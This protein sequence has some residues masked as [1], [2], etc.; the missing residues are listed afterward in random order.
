[1][2]SS[3]S[4]ANAKREIYM[5]DI[6]CKSQDSYHQFVL[7]SLPIGVAIL[8]MP[9]YIINLTNAEFARMVG[10]ASPACLAQGKSLEEALP[11]QWVDL[12]MPLVDEALDTDDRIMVCKV[13][14]AVIDSETDDYWFVSCQ[15]IPNCNSS[16]KHALIFSQD[17]SEES[18][19]LKRL[20][21]LN[22]LGSSLSRGYSLYEFLDDG[23]KRFASVISADYC[24]AF[25]LDQDGSRLLRVAESKPLDWAPVEIH[26]D[27]ACEWQWDAR[28][29]GPTYVCPPDACNVEARVLASIGAYG[30]LHIPVTVMGSL[31]GFIAAIF[32]KTGY[33]PPQED[34]EFAQL[35]AERCALAITT[36]K[37]MVEY[38]RLL[39]A[40]QALHRASTEKA[41]QMEALLESLECGVLIYDRNG[42]V[43]LSNHASEEIADLGK[44]GSKRRD[45]MAFN[46]PLEYLDGKIVPVEERPYDKLMREGSLVDEDYIIHRADGSTRVVSFS[47]GVI[48]D[49]G[50]MVSSA[51]LILRDITKLHEM[52][53]TRQEMVRLISHDLRSPLTLILAR[54]QM[55]ERL[56]DKPDAVRK[57]A[58]AIIT[59][60]KLMDVMISDLTDSF[61]LQS[62]EIRLRKQAL[63]VE[64]LISDCM[65]HWIGV[66]DLLRLRLDIEPDLPPVYGDSVRLE[67]IL[68]NL[69]TNAFKYSPKDSEVVIRVVL[70]Q[71]EEE[72]VISVI[73][74]G[75][76]VSK[77]ELPNIFERCYRD[78][79]AQN[80]TE[81]LGL[82]LYISKKLVE[83][84]GGRIW[85]RSVVGNGSTFSF[86]IPI[87]R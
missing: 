41:A 67:R 74:Q 27:S 18:V 63:D 1:M 43:S 49:S 3:D 78:P 81:G 83:A 2:Q 38:G 48:R 85:A 58:S 29:D 12:I 66:P 86:T 13:S 15:P 9:G 36:E 26:L 35:V 75:Q 73:D 51:I 25:L 76:G 5:E 8:H 11:K 82:G 87:A 54:A 30:Y 7:N 60:A 79:V 4:P 47:G 22:V 59:T 52:E 19:L 77:E 44:P 21:A 55:L 32:K 10:E 17:I 71:N 20:N 65:E 56:A 16:T 80:T 72:I 42:Y 31:M 28:S 64:R 45:D 70:G 53:Q 62:E 23:I 68:T 33:R 84:H 57:N 37:M 34:I 46:I 6:Y 39:S 50:G 40:E 14:Q 61:R 69:M 24:A